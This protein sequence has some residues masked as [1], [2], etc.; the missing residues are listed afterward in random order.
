MLYTIY[1]SKLTRASDR[2]AITA[3]YAIYRYAIKG[4][5]YYVKDKYSKGIR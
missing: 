4:G 5:N 3:I 1:Y 2:V